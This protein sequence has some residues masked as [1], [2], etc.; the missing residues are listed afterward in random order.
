MDKK[1]LH[2]CQL[3]VG[4]L[5][6]AAD[7]LG[8]LTDDHEQTLAK[9]NVARSALKVIATWAAFSNNTDDDMQKIETRCMDTLKLIE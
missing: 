7:R 4:R 6:K 2:Q 3:D 8:C 5:L 9:L 1:T